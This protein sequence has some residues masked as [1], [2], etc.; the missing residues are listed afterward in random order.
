MSREERKLEVQKK[1]SKSLHEQISQTCH[2]SDLLVAI[3]QERYTR[4]S[5]HNKH[6][7]CFCKE[8]ESTDVS[9][10]TKKKDGKKQ[11]SFQRETENINES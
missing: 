6:L 8:L 7:V 3:K 5:Q 11:R 10:T 9:T 2:R 1:T 4:K